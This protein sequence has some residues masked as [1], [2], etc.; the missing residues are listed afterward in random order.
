MLLKNNWLFNLNL[1]HSSEPLWDHVLVWSCTS[2]YPF[3]LQYS[4]HGFDVGFLYYSEQFD[5]CYNC[6]FFASLHRRQFIKYEQLIEF[7]K[8]R[9]SCA[10]CGGTTHPFYTCRK[11][12]SK[13]HDQH[14]VALKEK[15]LCCNWLNL[16]HLKLQCSSLRRCQWCQRPHPTLLRQDYDKM[17]LQP[18]RGGKV[19]EGLT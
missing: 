11:F 8:W 12:R 10:V 9:D 2:N 15:Q 7:N 13:P 14:L 17:L 16:R 5:V 19:H 1:Q 6:I 4:T 18:L 3:I